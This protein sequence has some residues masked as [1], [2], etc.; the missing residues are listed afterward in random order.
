MATRAIAQRRG[1]PARVA[2]PLATSSRRR[3]AG[4]R[5]RARPPQVASVASC[6]EP[7]VESCQTHMGSSSA[8]LARN[9]ERRAP[10]ER[11]RAA[12][13]WGGGAGRAR[14]AAPPHP[15]QR[16][17]AHVS[18]LTCA[19]RRPACSG[20]RSRRSSTPWRCV[21]PRP[22]PRQRGRGGGSA[23]TG[24]GSES[25]RRWSAPRG[26]G[27]LRRA[28]RLR[29]A[30]LRGRNASPAS[31]RRPIRQRRRQSSGAELPRD[32][33][34]GAPGGKAH[35]AP[36]RA[37]EHICRA[38][39]LAQRPSSAAGGQSRWTSS[40]VAAGTRRLG[41]RGSN[42]RTPRNPSR[43]E[44]RFA[45]RK[46]PLPMLV[47]TARRIGLRGANL[48]TTVGPDSVWCTDSARSIPSEAP[49]TLERERDAR[50]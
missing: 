49:I 16:T 48:I 7:S 34:D 47:G 25:A 28:G 18:H 21:H 45:S 14:T 41:M 26:A 12:W 3:A 46:P 40:S 24:P 29:A 15:S 32:G 9:I 38:T 8:T 42:S 31:L 39:R 11:A 37:N 30:D 4:G 10:G 36:P 2:R 50:N 22:G 43:P 17:L 5:R 35:G 20:S 13:V 33:D 27:E 6:L 23:L 44:L 1:A 19:R